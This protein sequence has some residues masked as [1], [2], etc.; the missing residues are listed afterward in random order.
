MSV[1]VYEYE[2]GM[3]VVLHLYFTVSDAMHMRAYGQSYSEV[4]VLLFKLCHLLT[5]Q[6]LLV[7]S[8]CMLDILS[9]FIFMM[10]SRCIFNAIIFLPKVQFRKTFCCFIFG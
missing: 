6:C 4:N 10:I 3:T 1:S 2:H 5:V 9:Y 7:E 8:V